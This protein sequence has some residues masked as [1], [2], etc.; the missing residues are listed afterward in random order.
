M[1]RR[2]QLSLIEAIG[3]QPAL[4]ASLSTTMREVEVTTFR[5]LGSYRRKALSKVKKPWTLS[6]KT[7]LSRVILPVPFQKLPI[8]PSPMV[9]AK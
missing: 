3:Q 7:I 8:D 5:T 2:L 9:K 4:A 6:H 1:G